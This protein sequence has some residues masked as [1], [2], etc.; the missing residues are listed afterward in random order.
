MN[1]TA[2]YNSR[3]DRIEAKI[4]KLADAVVSIARAEERMDAL[5]DTN[6]RLDG[7]IRSVTEKVYK[8]TK[9]VDDN[10]RTSQW[11]TRIGY[12]I[13]ASFVALLAAEA[14][15]IISGMRT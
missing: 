4:D 2:E 5:E 1:T 10:T 11:V 15:V 9:D 8:L 3:L 13:I 14:W 7:E 6:K 12:A